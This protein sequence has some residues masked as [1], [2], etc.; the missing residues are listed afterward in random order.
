M[1]EA[2]GAKKGPDEQWPDFPRRVSFLVDPEGVVRRVYEVT[3]TAGHAQQ[4]LDDLRALQAAA[5]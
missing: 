3:D 5:T 1:G 2:Y 4:V